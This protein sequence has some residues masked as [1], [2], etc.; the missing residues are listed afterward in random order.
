MQEYKKLPSPSPILLLHPISQPSKGEKDPK[1]LTQQEHQDR[2]WTLSKP[3]LSFKT[4]TAPST[5]RRRATIEIRWVTSPHRWTSPSAWQ[6]GKPEE[7]SSSMARLMIEGQSGLVLLTIEWPVLPRPRMRMSTQLSFQN[8]SSTFQD[9][10][11][12]PISP[13]TLR[14]WGLVFW[15]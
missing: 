3:K 2:S 8:T 11:C 7:S 15:T 4:N 5:W 12:P 10:R 13:S 14:S 1:A 9:T 6:M